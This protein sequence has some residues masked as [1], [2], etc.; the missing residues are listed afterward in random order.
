M[1]NTRWYNIYVFLR[2]REMWMTFVRSNSK[3]KYQNLKIY[4]KK[5]KLYFDERK[6]TILK[7]RNV[8]VKDLP[9]EIK[10][11]YAFDSCWNNFIEF[12]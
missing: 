11:I 10:F 3:Y 9:H 2:D 6:M 4:Y 5:I 7:Y 12:G 1:V 8:S